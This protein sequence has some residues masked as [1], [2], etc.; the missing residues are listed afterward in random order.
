[1]A[2]LPE[3]SFEPAGYETWSFY[4]P[5]R[6]VGG[7]YLGAFPLA[8]PGDRTG[9]P[10]R[11]WALAVGD[12]TGHG[13]P[14]ALF[15]ARLSAEVRQVLQGEVDPARCL[16]RL[17]RQITAD[18]ADGFFVTFLMATIDAQNHR[19]ASATAGHLAPMLRRA[20]GGPIERIGQEANG[21]PLAVE[22]DSEYRVVDTT[23]E[24]G[25]VIVLCTDGIYEAMNAELDCLGIGRLEQVIQSAPPGASAV[26]EAI[27]KAVRDHAR[28]CPQADDMTILCIGRPA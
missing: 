17:N 22:E 20:R 5:A 24:P 4:E 19:L 13:M 26:G 10:A 23:I 15:L 9:G 18:A 28:G 8:D 21:L 14:A 11:R 2:L 27:V 6:R 3:R 1:M 12:V 25:D 16:A 7:D